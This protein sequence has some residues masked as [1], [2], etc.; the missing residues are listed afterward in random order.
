MGGAVGHLSH[1]WDDLTLTFEQLEDMLLAACYGKLERV[2]E[3]LDG[4]NLVF[5]V[6]HAGLR[7]ARNKGNIVSGGLD[8]EGLATKFA[9]R[10]TVFEAFVAAYDV[11]TQIVSTMPQRDVS[12][13]FAGGDR[14]FSAEVVYS[15][16]VNV[17]TYDN[18]AI[19]VHDT[20]VFEVQDGAV[21]RLQ[22]SPFSSIIGGYAKRADV[23]GWRTGGAAP[24]G[25]KRLASG[26]H[27]RGV[28]NG[29]RAI[30][31]TYGLRP[32]STLH[33]YM[34]SGI[35]DA[36]DIEPALAAAM[37]SR[38]NG[39]HDAP[40]LRDIRD[41]FPDA[42]VPQPGAVVTAKNALLLRIERIVRDVGAAVLADASSALIND[43]DD[44]V[45]RLGERLRDAV[46]K[47]RSSG[48]ANAIATLQHELERIPNHAVTA[49]IEG[50]VFVYD[51]KA[52]KLT[53]GFQPISILLRVAAELT[54]VE[55]DAR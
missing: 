19:I 25:L 4:M 9:G 5:T 24:V 47:I 50:V 33:D 49:A 2:S 44:A 17:I 38:A 41:A 7:I 40:T 3:K 31:S 22:S 37:L 39:D 46:S 6:S 20:P 14:W 10:G 36:L 34:C 54:N 16:F 35:A 1:P 55:G 51:G 13:A 42:T 21:E 18:S 8:R 52:Y 29:L 53:G 48:N 23:S 30:R 11:L 28:V 32:S 27:A 12:R 43:R 15:P 45:R 26:W